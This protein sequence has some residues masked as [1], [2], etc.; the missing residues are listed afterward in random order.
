M[1]LQFKI[2]FLFGYILKQIIFMWWPRWIFI[3]HY[4]SHIIVINTF[5]AYLLKK[6][7]NF[8]FFFIFSKTDYFYDVSFS[9]VVFLSPGYFQKYSVFHRKNESLAGLQACECD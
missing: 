7:I 9:Y 5:N 3:S 2:T 4:S 1:L 8:L 6:I